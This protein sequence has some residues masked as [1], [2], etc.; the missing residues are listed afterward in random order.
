MLAYLLILCVALAGSVEKLGAADFDGTIRRSA[1]ALVEFYAD[2][3]GHCASLAP[4]YAE[5]ARQLAA[6][7][8][9][10]VAK[11][12]AIAQIDLAH[13]F[14][15]TGYPTILVF[16]HGIPTAPERYSGPRTVD[17]LVIAALHALRDSPL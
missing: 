13:R 15:V 9:V 14:G 5:A 2:R 16:R 3:C 10:L 12:D 8:S 11:V 4:V 17:A 1:V 7:P 6:E